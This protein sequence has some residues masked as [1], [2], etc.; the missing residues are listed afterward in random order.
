MEQ[1]KPL[2][3]KALEYGK[4]KGKTPEDQVSEASDMLFVLF[5]HEILKVIPG[6]V[7]TEIDARLSFD[8]AASVKKALKLISMYE[9]L[10]I[11]KERILIKLASTWEGI[12]AAKELESEHGVHW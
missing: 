12:Q 7:S 5:G 3:E 8:K 11:K 9:E 4:S 2:I 10:G 6:R 1:Y